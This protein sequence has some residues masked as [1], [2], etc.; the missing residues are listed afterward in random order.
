MI[1]GGNKTISEY[2][3][4]SL[5]YRENF[6]SNPGVSAALP[7]QIQRDAGKT[8]KLKNFENKFILFHQ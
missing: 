6:F 5:S 4:A 1:P 2:V 7:A 3:H 8:E